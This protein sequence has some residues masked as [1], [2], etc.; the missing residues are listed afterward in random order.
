VCGV[1]MHI[2]YDQRSAS[3]A[4]GDVLLTLVPPV[5]NCGSHVGHC[6]A[7]PPRHEITEHVKTLGNFA[8]FSLLT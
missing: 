5:V 7:E 2:G 3:P 6:S 8:V 4:R 1:E